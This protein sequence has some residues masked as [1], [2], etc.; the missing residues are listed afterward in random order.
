M[1]VSIDIAVNQA[2]FEFTNQEMKDIYKFIYSKCEANIKERFKNKT[3]KKTTE[4]N[5]TNHKVRN[6]Y[7]LMITKESRTHAE[8]VDYL[9]GYYFLSTDEIYAIIEPIKEYSLRW[10][11]FKRDGKEI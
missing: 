2:P 9:A 8:I 6:H 7:R 11:K 10:G 5:E 3:F 1:G 4:N